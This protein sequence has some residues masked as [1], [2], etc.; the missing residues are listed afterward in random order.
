M[1]SPSAPLNINGIGGS[2]F[3]TA[4]GDMNAGGNHFY[5]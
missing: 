5:H 2:H 1:N 3:N 4:R